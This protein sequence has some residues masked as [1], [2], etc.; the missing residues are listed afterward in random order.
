MSLERTGPSV[1]LGWNCSYKDV[2][3][4]SYGSQA[5][6]SVEVVVVH[7]IPRK[8]RG[9]LSPRVGLSILSGQWNHR[10]RPEL[11]RRFQA[12]RLVLAAVVADA[13]RR[14]VAVIRD[15]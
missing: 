1:S 12:A 10:T 6:C 8:A 11:N 13:E 15:E 14:G 2:R 9:G 3:L 4:D 5:F 7:K